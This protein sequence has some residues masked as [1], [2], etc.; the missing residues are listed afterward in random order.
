M[1]PAEKNDTETRLYVLT[2]LGKLI[3]LIVKANFSNKEKHNAIKE[4]IDIVNSIKEQNDSAIVL[5]ITKLLNQ[6]WENNKKSSII[7]HLERL[8]MLELNNG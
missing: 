6:L 5:F 1:V 8:L 3:L 7:H 4:I 2:P